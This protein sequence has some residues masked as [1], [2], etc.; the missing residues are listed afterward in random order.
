MSTAYRR[1]AYEVTIN[2]DLLLTCFMFE[3]AFFQLLLNEYELINLFIY[4]FI[5]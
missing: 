2:V 5:N 4:L 3:V 1:T